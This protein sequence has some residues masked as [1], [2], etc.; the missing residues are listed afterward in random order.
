MIKGSI[1][2]D[3]LSVT[4]IPPGEDAQ[5]LRISTLANEFR[6]YHNVDIIH[7]INERSNSLKF[8]NNKDRYNKDSVIIASPVG[9]FLTHF[10]I[11]RDNKY[12]LVYGNTFGGAFFSLTGKLLGIPLVLDMHG[13]SNE[14]LLE[15]NSNKGIKIKRHINY[16]IK[17]FME[18]ISLRFS[19]KIICVSKNMIRYL[20][21]EKKVPLYKMI[22]G[23]NGVD[24]NLFKP[25]DDK[26][27]GELK[28]ELGIDKKFV[29]G[30][31]GAFQKYQG[32][33]HFIEAAKKIENQ[34]VVFL[35]VGGSGNYLEDNR[36]VIPKVSRD[37]VPIYYAI[38]D[39]LVLPRPKHIS[40]EVAA[41]TKFAEYCAMGKPILTTDVGDAADLV[42]TYK[43]GIVI[44]DNSPENLEKGI[45]EFLKLDSF[46]LFEMGNNS[47]KLAENEFDWKK[48]LYNIVKG[49][50]ELA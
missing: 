44:K 9:L 39:V 30:Y 14:D 31:V 47:R 50:S 26:E 15:L 37:Q 10:K 48:I 17:Y 19:D 28:K 34:E 42:R 33:D 13:T 23:T 41:P 8:A 25:L 45:L 11:L 2:M 40:M 4:L 46:T 5:W 24:L 18:L 22:Y 35:F 49:L 20:H 43:N 38:C 3:I 36:I 6:K 12:N 29:I 16:Y 1:N 7:Y 27:I 32:I 21:N